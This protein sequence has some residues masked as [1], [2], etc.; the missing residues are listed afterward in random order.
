MNQQVE[1]LS[2]CASSLWW[3]EA[4]DEPAREDDRPT[5]RPQLNWPQESNSVGSAQKMLANVLRV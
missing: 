1:P 5:H 3:G 2:S 4:T